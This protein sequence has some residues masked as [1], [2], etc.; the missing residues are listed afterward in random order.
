MI[1][2]TNQVLTGTHGRSFLADLLI[3]P[4]QKAQPVLLFLHGFKGF[5]DWGAQPEIARYMVQQGM[6]F[7][8]FNY[9]FNGTTLA[10]PESF[11]DPEAF[12]QNNFSKELDDTGVMIDWL[13]TEA[14]QY[15]GLLDMEKLYLIGHSRGGGIAI[16]KAAEDRRVKKIVT[17]ASVSEF[18]KFWKQDQM[19][20][21][22]REGVI[23]VE[24]TR[25]GERL[26]LYRQLY[27]DYALNRQRL[28][29]PERAAA[30]HCPMLVIHG[31]ADASVPVSAAHDLCRYQPAA[32]LQLIEGADHTFGARHPHSGELPDALRQV[33]DY[34]LSFFSLSA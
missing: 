16:L 4:Q 29:I 32:S 25:T 15:P 31:T 6:A 21:I 17:W 7:A 13:F 3:H 14:E 11:A 22:M 2:L 24:N 33:C 5:K 8:R 27:E 28:Y 1:S 23:Y 19:E 9:A 30:L 34:T 12:G 10:H 18:G 20:Q 26:P